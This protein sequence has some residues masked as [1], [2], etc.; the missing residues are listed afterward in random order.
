MGALGWPALCRF[1]A[2]LGHIDVVATDLDGTLLRGDGTIS[3]RTHAALAAAAESGLVVVIVTARPFRFLAEID[4]LEVH[5]VAVCVNGA[6]IVD[7]ATRAHITAHTLDADATTAAVTALR[8]MFPDVAFGVERV[9]VCGHEPHYLSQ[10]PLPEGSPIGPIESLI[11]DGVL[12][13]LG[14]HPQIHVDGL[15]AMVDAIG[16]GAT[17]TC[18]MTEGMVEIGPAGVTK[19]SALHEVVALLGHTANEVLA[20]GDMPNDLAMLRW[21]ATSA[22]VANAHPDLLAEVDLVLPANDDDGVASLLE[23]LTA[24]R[25]L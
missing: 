2:V 15:A 20:V 1:G 7:L 9:D 17:V 11:G 21:A 14:R 22:A 3:E 19:A 25:T 24:A 16:S 23:A 12:K 5:G 6:L 10:W 4:R 13:L 8:G 18:S